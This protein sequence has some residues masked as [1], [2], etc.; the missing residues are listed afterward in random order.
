MTVWIVCAA[1]FGV[2]FVLTGLLANPH[3][4]LNILDYPQTRSLHETPTPRT[5]GLG[6][7][8]GLALSVLT[9]LWL[10]LPVLR[11]PYVVGGLAL[12]A[13]ISALDDIR[14]RPAWLRLLVHAGAALLLI[15][16]GYQIETLALPGGW[17]LPLG[18]AGP[19]IT[20]LFVVWMANLYNFMD[21]MDGLA[22]GMGAI[23]F[24][25]LAL[26]G[27]LAGQAAFALSAGLVALTCL[28]FLL[29]NF[30]PARIFLGDLGAI[31]LGYLA[32]AFTLVGRREGLFAEWLPVLVFSAFVMD[33]TVT[34]LK[35]LAHA[36]KIWRPHRT[37]Y[38]Q[39]LVLMGWSQRRTALAYYSVMLLC[40]AT[41][42]ALVRLGRPAADAAAVVAWC[43]VYALLAFQIER[44]ERLEPLPLWRGLLARL[45]GR[46]L[47]LAHDV[48]WVPLAVYIA[49][50]QRYNYLPP[51]DDPGML[52]MMAVT[53]PV[54]GVVFWTLGLHR[55]IWPKLSFADL[56]KLVRA[57]MLG[58]GVSGLLLFMLTRFEG[59]PRSVFVMFPVV[60]GLGLIWPRSLYRWRAD[61]R[62]GPSFADRTRVMIVGATGP[63]DQLTSELLRG[64]PYLPVALLDS[65]PRLKGRSL[66]GVRVVGDLGQAGHVLRTRGVQMAVLAA[67]Q[68]TRQE[69]GQ[70][71]AAC[72]AAHVPVR[73]LHFPEAGAQGAAPQPALRPV[74]LADLLRPAAAGQDPRPVVQA[75][76]EQRVLVTGAGGAAGG[77]LAHQIAAAGPASLIVL[78]HD[79]HGL[80]A[81]KTALET[82]Y[83]QLPVHAVLG[84]VNLGHSVDEVFRRLRPQIVFH[85]AAYSHAPL[86][87]SNPLQALQANVFGTR[88]VALAADRHGAASMVLLST[89]KAAHPVNVMG[90][91]KRLAER[92]CQSL[93]ARSKTRF[94]A[95]RLG[96]ALGA[97]GSIVPQIEAQI[98][99]GGPVTVSH[100]EASR[101]FLPLPELVRLV[102]HAFAL[103]EGGEV[104]LAEMGP[105]VTL[106]EL[107]ED[108]IRLAGRLPGTDIPIV[109][110]GLAPG[111]LLREEPSTAR[112]ELTPTAHPAILR[113][114]QQRLD[115]SWLDAELEVL[116]QAITRGDS[117]A[118][119]AQLQRLVPEFTPTRSEPGQDDDARPPR[120]H[121]V[122]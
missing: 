107:A 86:L 122:K 112:G 9:A 113:A 92:V 23:G 77:E 117:A 12:V 51:L 81:L 84:D 6:L 68:A 19:L 8:I 2:A 5:G 54:F 60:L 94:I 74:T 11:D 88:E 99:R 63:G 73:I 83:P 56:F 37:H 64:S 41:A 118:A 96:S 52:W 111:E 80:Q 3:W 13:G 32:A 70:L 104:F 98:A 90:A 16:G 22:G 34:L 29:H 105:P 7:L 24:G 102:L 59:V 119:L 15:A 71:V 114:A 82:A 17:E 103:G 67:P 43:L 39:R 44:L 108:M 14:S 91:S 25:A 18:S 87:E 109:Y 40:S 31:S 66:H 50:A 27:A 106:K 1:A 35:R 49:Y 110:T 61:Q 89:D 36:E 101:A 100:P 46:A 78:D 72:A 55:D 85:A 97:L 21:G 75:L 53:V 93:D 95:F 76:R 58:L 62:S 79:E 45:N 48:A 120:L 121:V 26:L 4:P 115:W 38:F 20:V 116:R 69:I 28:G 57:L 10:E 42:V 65:D 30:H 47:V 33:A